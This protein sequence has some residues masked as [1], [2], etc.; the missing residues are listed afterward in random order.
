[1][2]A[3]VDLAMGRPGADAQLVVGLVDAI[4]PGDVAQVDEQGGLGEPELD[5]R[6]EAVAAG[7]QL[8]LAFAVRQDL[9]RS[10]R[11]AGRT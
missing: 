6:D 3:L 10:S 8:R 5:E 9:Q 4:E 7:Q 11:S 1:M 2:S